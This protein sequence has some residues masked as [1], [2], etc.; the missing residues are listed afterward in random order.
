MKD[1]AP[2]ACVNTLTLRR[3]Q[4]HARFRRKIF[5]S[6]DA[7]VSSSTAGEDRFGLEDHAV[8]AA[9]RPIV[10][11]VMLIGGP[12]PQIVRLDFNQSRS[13]RSPQ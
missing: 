9:K 10:N 8:A 1:P 4:N 6:A 3:Q 12:L 11:D 5:F 13:S 2:A 7:P